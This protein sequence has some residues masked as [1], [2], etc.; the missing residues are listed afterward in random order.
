MLA[1]PCSINRRTAKV[2]SYFELVCE[3]LMGHGLRP[4][5]F[6]AD[7]FHEQAIMVPLPDFRDALY[8]L[9]RGDVP[10]AFFGP[11]Y[12]LFEVNIGG[13]RR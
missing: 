5:D 13:Q 8:Q 2:D 10:E 1:R 6:V 12:Q 3:R 4:H 7:S 11:D 9:L